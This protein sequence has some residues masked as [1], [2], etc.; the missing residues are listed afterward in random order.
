M[1]NNWNRMKWM[2]PN[3]RPLASL[4]RALACSILCLVTSSRP[5][6]IIIFLWR[7]HVDY[8]IIISI[9]LYFNLLHDTS[10]G[11]MYYL[12]LG[13]WQKQEKRTFIGFLYMYIYNYIDITQILNGGHLHFVVTK[14]FQSCVCP[15]GSRSTLTGIWLK[16]LK[17]QYL[18]TYLCALMLNITRNSV[19]LQQ[20]PSASL[21]FEGF[22]LSPV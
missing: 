9:F 19:T 13:K 1:Y 5:E 22:Y 4:D 10:T 20:N 18:I 7:A 15:P 21:H 3:S 14:L 6:C 16:F 2:H 11:L 17:L 12:P 8:F